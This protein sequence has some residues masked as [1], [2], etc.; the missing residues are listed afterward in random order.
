M[1]GAISIVTGAGAISGA[2]GINTDTTDTGGIRIRSGSGLATGTAGPGIMAVTEDGPINIAIGNGGVTTS[3]SGHAII[4]ASTNGNI[5]VT[6]KGT[7]SGNFLC[8]VGYCSAGGVL[9][10]SDG[11]ANIRIGG[12]GTYS[13]S[14][15]GRAIYAEQDANGL[16]GI[17]ITGSGPTFAGTD[18]FGQ[19]SAICAAIDNPADSSNIVVNR[20]GDIGSI[21]TIPAGFPYSVSA[22]VHAFTAGAGN[23]TVA[24][25]AGAT[26]S[27]AAFPNA[28]MFG[29][30][31]S[32]YGKDS[33]GNIKVSTGVLST[34]TAN[35]TG[36]FAD[37]S[38]TAIP[39]SAGSTI[40]VKANGSINSGTIRN[41]VGQLP[42]EGGGAIST[43]GGILAGYNGGPVFNAFATGPYTSCGRFGCT[44]LTPNPKV[45]GTVNV[46]NNAA[47][48]AKGGDGIFAFNFGNGN[49]SVKSRAP[50]TVTGSSAKNGIEAF[51]AEIGKISVVASANVSGGNGNGVK[52][53]SAGTAKTTVRIRGGTTEGATSGVTALSAGGPIQI[54]N[55]ATIRNTSGLASD[56]AVAALGSRNAILANDTDAVLTGT[57]S[58]TGT[59]TNQ[60]ANGGIWNVLSTSTFAGSSSITNSGDINVFGVTTFRGLTTLDNGGTLNLATGN[61]AVTLKSS[62]NLAY[63]SGALYVVYLT[64]TKSSLTDVVGTASLAG[65]VSAVFASGSYLLKQYDILHASSVTGRFSD[66]NVPANYKASLSYTSTDVLLS[67]NPS[68]GAGGSLNVNQ[69]NVAASINNFLNSG[70]TLP[71]NFDNLFG[72]TGGN[73]TNAL[74]QS[75]GEPSVDSEFAA[76]QMTTEFL[77]LC[78]TRSSRDASVLASAPSADK[79]WRLRPTKRRVCHRTSRS[80]TPACLRQ[81]RRRSRRTGP[82]GARATA[83]VTGLAATR[84]SAQ[85][86]LRH[87]PTALPA[88]W[89]TIIRRMRSLVSR[90]AGAAPIGRS[91]AAAADEAMRSRVAFTG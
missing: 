71:S 63:Q 18:A 91:P 66:I 65:T 3:S 54:E 50:I 64:P 58:M 11:T 59:K 22:D 86:M 52:T 30:E 43:P 69:Q 21:N 17:T 48:D 70:R 47:I 62:G 76:F 5:S 34:L 8:D 1:G 49:V 40:E 20:S 32:A 82:S 56:S 68:L 78:S 10:I 57:V 37:N 60:F 9:A 16:G 33:T 87:K 15:G 14:S 74:R 72:L 77:N 2:V 88:A 7:V 36:I 23:I 29:I 27:N 75:D 6:A 28:G 51:S 73:L 31:V 38:A 39:V 19:A 25:G 61:T 53:T 83:Q 79:R 45:N 46:I 4:A 26:L 89:I 41:P 13:S 35:G 44:T 85:A 80:L 55:A 42:E 67:L 12:S 90:S 24:G 84:P 81:R